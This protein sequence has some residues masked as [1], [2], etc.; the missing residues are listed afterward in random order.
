[1]IELFYFLFYY[2][3]L[4]E[5]LIYITCSG[6]SLLD[7]RQYSWEIPQCGIGTMAVMG[8]LPLW[9]K[10]EALLGLLQA[11]NQASFCPWQM[12]FSLNYHK[13]VFNWARED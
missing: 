7:S 8:A 13:Y 3:F 4:F 1:M 10:C 9:E 6:L 11:R 5:A 2:F 12:M